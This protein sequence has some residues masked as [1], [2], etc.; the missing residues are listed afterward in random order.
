MAYE[1]KNRRKLLDKGKPGF[2]PDSIA[3]EGITPLSHISFNTKTHFYEK[4]SCFPIPAW[5]PS[6][7]GSHHCIK[8]IL[9]KMC[10]GAAYVT[11]SKQK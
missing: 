11:Y 2:E 9:H 4:L 10:T 6:A 8:Q 7:Q 1:A 3:Y 5:L